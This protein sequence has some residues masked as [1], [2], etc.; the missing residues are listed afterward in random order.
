MFF[1]LLAFS[2]YLRFIGPA[3]AQVSA[4][5]CTYSELAWVCSFFVDARIVLI[6]ARLSRLAGN[7]FYSRSIRSNKAPVWSQRTWRQYATMAV[8]T[9]TFQLA[10]RVRSYGHVAASS[11]PALQPGNSYT[12]PSGLDDDD[13]C[14][15][16]TVLYNLISACD[17]CQGESW[18]SCVDLSL[19]SPG[20]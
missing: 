2:F 3:G 8:S 18:I 1:P 12:G 10:H 7:Y 15:C 11:I 19:F 17:A 9:C 20:F 6:T 5:N 14:K 4:P 16:N 13:Q